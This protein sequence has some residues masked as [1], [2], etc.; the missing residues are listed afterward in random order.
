MRTFEQEKDLFFID[1]SAYDLLQDHLKTTVVCPKDEFKGHILYKNFHVSNCHRTWKITDYDYVIVAR[2]GWYE[3]LPDEMQQL[4]LSEQRRTGSRLVLGDLLITQHYWRSLS[5]ENQQKLIRLY[6]E[7]IEDIDISGLPERFQRLH[8][9]YPEAH[10]GNCFAAALYGVAD[11]SFLL[12][13]WVHSQSFLDMLERNN[14]RRF[15]RATKDSVLV[16]VQEGVVVHAC[17]VIDDEYC[18]NKSGQTFFNPWHIA[19]IDK[20]I[21]DWDDCKVMFFCAPDKLD[22]LVCLGIDDKQVA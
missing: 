14:F 19:R 13:E 9:Q 3:E 15:D 21:A 4:I 6:D 8:G 10:G 20:V 5:E 17:Y 16:F 22:Q 12:E 1:S 18:F 7:R 2:P 11:E